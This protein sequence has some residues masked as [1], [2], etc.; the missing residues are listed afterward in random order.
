M[1]SKESKMGKSKLPLTQVLIIRYTGKE[2]QGYS[3]IP[4]LNLYV[5]KWEE[6]LIGGDKKI[7]DG[8]TVLLRWVLW[9]VSELQSDRHLRVFRMIGCK[10]GDRA[11]VVAECA[12]GALSLLLLAYY[13]VAVEA[14]QG[15]THRFLPS[16]ICV[17]MA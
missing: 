8:D 12:F 2:I 9:N 11:G 3:Q 15:G 1:A 17:V 10:A 4:Y 5:K 7:M 14:N 13:A 16:Y 6:N